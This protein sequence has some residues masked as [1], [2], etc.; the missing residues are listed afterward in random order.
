VA[1][2]GYY[3]DD[4]GFSL[5][6]EVRDYQEMGLAGMKLKVGGRS[7]DEDVARLNTVMGAA[8]GGFRVV[9]DANRGWTVEQAVEFAER[10]EEHDVYWFEEPVV[11]YDQYEGMRRVGE[12]TSVPI[13]AG[14]NECVPEG[15]RVLV[16]RS[17]VDVLNFDAS[18]GGGPTTWL[19]VAAAAQQAGVQMAH[20][21]EPHV[22]MHLLASVPNGLHVECFH[23]DIDPIW[24]DMH[25]NRPPVEDGNI[26]LPDRPGLGIDIDEEFVNTY[27]VE[28]ASYE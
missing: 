27:R 7:V 11:W 4:D 19:R 14:Q 2:G 22:A 15:C 20:H 21:E 13:A 8:D 5:E 23:P 3:A 10:T 17:D 25:S 16:E 28:T 12:R 1:T 26:E 9:C 18:Y 6:R 24:Y